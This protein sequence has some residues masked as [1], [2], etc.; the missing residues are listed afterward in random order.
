M[1][2]LQVTVASPDEI[3]MSPPSSKK[4][5]YF[6]KLTGVLSPIHHSSSS[7]ETSSAPEP[8][9]ATSEPSKSVEGKVAPASPPPGCKS[10]DTAETAFKKITIPSFTVSYEIEQL[11]ARHKPSSFSPRTVQR[12]TERNVVTTTP[13]SFPMTGKAPKPQPL[14]PTQLSTDESPFHQSQALAGLSA[15]QVANGMIT[16]QITPAQYT[17]IVQAVLSRKPTSCATS[18]RRISEGHLG[19]E[20]SHLPT[21]PLT[22]N[23]VSTPLPNIPDSN[24]TPLE[25]VHQ[26]GGDNR[27]GQNDQVH[28]TNPQVQVPS[29]SAL[30]KSDNCLPHAKQPMSLH[31]FQQL[32]PA[33][34]PSQAEF[35]LPR[36]H[37]L[38]GH[39]SLNRQPA[40]NQHLTHNQPFL[41]QYPSLNQQVHIPNEHIN[42]PQN[43]P[44]CSDRGSVPNHT[45]VSS[46]NPTPNSA[47]PNQPQPG[48]PP[49]VKPYP[50]PETIYKELV[51]GLS[52]GRFTL[53]W[54]LSYLADLRYAHTKLL[55]AYENTKREN[56]DLGK[57]WKTAQSTMQ[58][59]FDGRHTTPDEGQNQ[60][61]GEKRVRMN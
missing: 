44:F 33:P 2:S 11:A 4:E 54:T 42:H 50:P 21:P 29:H 20:H 13:A 38:P 8:L 45:G 53:D 57:R 27:L 18:G 19:K 9:A 25:N 34:L 24:M 28:H 51:D 14:K 17:E 31:T 6:D 48:N 59:I 39:S 30:S 5:E 55:Q 35:H 7:S 10:T 52:T 3:I 43:R 15:S 22:I 26:V 47:L 32:Y 49:V 36:T 1:S 61:R 58:S 56:E 46:T 41:S 40:L 12:L 37:S 16:L 23:T 60:R